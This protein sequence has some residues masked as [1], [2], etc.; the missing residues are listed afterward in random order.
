MDWVDLHKQVKWGSAP[1][2]QFLT[3]IRALSPPGKVLRILDLG[4]GAG[5]NSIVLC[6]LG[7]EVYGVDIS[8]D[9]IAHLIDRLSSDAKFSGYACDVRSIDFEPDT[10]DVILDVSALCYLSF[11]D[12]YL[13][14]QR[15]SKWLK[16]GGHTFATLPCDEFDP[17]MMRGIPLRLVTAEQVSVIYRGWGWLMQHMACTASMLP[18]KS[19]RRCD[20][21]MVTACNCQL[22]R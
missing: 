4:C 2:E 17:I 8:R 22:R 16:P 18:D 14:M 19:D 15:I 3:F 6:E 21:F 5:A 12:H 11:E 20:H 13:Y 1:N 7:H 10:F 9:A